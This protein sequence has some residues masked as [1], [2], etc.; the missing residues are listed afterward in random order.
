MI[1][2]R[3][4]SFLR[5]AAVVLGLG[6][7]VAGPVAAEK[8]DR[9]K[10]MVIEADRPGTVDLQRQLVVFNGNV[11]ISQGTLNIHADRVELRE[12]PDGYR[13][14]TAIGSPD[15]QARYRQK[16]DGVDETV[17]GAAD[18]I[19]FDGRAQTLRFVGHGAVRRYRGAELADEITGSLIVWNAITEVFSVQGGASTPANPS[20]RVRAVLSPRA[21]GKA[22]SPPEPAAS[23]ALKP[24]RALGEHR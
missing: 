24:S 6:L 23:V 11:S 3:P 10:Q 8:A 5:C 15:H 12:M 22:A 9:E 1:C 16:R 18:R 13:E 19:E 2:F 7:A 4:T 14:A 21:D 20:G 17:E